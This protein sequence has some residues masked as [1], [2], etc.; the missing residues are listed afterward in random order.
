LPQVEEDELRRFA[1]A[2]STQPLL[3]EF[4]DYGWPQSLEETFFE[5][6]VA[7]A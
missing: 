7:F 6:R 4:P 5:L 3:T 2:R 1:L